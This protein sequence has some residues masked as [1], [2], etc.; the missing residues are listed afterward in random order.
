[1]DISGFLM[2][3]GGSLME[4]GGPLVEIGRLTGEDVVAHWWRSGG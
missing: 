1:M 4:I 3:I 2:E